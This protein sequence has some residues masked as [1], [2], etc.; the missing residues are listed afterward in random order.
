MSPMID[1]YDAIRF[2]NIYALVIIPNDFALYVSSI[3]GY[4]KVK[5]YPPACVVLCDGT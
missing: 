1:I 5:L 2:R 4:Y 3:F